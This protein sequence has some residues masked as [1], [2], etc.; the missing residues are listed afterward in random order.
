[1]IYFVAISYTVDG[2]SRTSTRRQEAATPLQAKTAALNAFA[3]G[4]DGRRVKITG[5]TVR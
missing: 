4:R 5:S 2:K 3:A 1:M